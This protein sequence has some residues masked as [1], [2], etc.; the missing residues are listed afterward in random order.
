MYFSEASLLSRSPFR[1][2]TITYEVMDTISRAR[3]SMARSLAAARSRFEKVTAS[4]SA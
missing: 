4:I 3:Y 2:A 1:Y